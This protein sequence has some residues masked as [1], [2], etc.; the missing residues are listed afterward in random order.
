MTNID[1]NLLAP[2]VLADPYP[3]L[4]HLRQTDPVHW[5][6]R[7]QTWV[8]TRYDDFLWVTRSPALFSSEVARREPYTPPP[9]PQAPDENQATPFLPAP[10]HKLQEQVREVQANTMAQRDHKAHTTM[11]QVVHHFFTPKALAR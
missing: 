10:D 9:L 7:H 11:R 8:I 5:N 2:E 1:D 6:A 3:Y 4:A